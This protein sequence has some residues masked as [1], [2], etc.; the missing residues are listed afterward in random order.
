MEL[1]KRVGELEREVSQL[2]VE[3]RELKI[4]NSN[5]RRLL[6]APLSMD[7]NFLPVKVIGQTRYLIIDKGREG[8]IQVDMVLIFE[9]VLV[10][11]VVEVSERLAKVILPSD[12]ESQI[13][14]KTKTARGMVIG[15]GEG[16][17]LDKV[18]QK[19]ELRVDDL[20]ITSGEDG[21]FPANLLIGKIKEIEKEERQPFQKAQVEPLVDY[22]KLE[23]VF[24][25][26][27]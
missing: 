17:F 14:V 11:R 12:S 18:L 4:E 24:L 5:S 16:L 25:I 15:E 10:G 2:R 23:T 7:W 26:I 27:E 9:K 3:N 19:E 21:I 22:D 13:K 1:K 8:Q 6:G 20:V